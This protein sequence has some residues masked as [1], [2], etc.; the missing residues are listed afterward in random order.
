MS[1]KI[2]ISIIAAA[3][4]F[5]VLAQGPVPDFKP[6]TTFSGST[7]AGWKPMGSAEWKA[8]NGE[9][10]GTGK[11]SGG[12]LV[13]DKSYQDAGFFA[14]F[15]CSGEC[16]QG[17]LLRAQKTAD[18]MK[19]I[20]VSLAAGDLAT[21]S[22]T[23]DKEGREVSRTP[24]PPVAPFIRVAPT[25]T[26]A[27][28]AGG[29]GAGDRAVTAGRSAAGRGGR[30]MTLPVTLAPLM[31]PA[32]GLKKD[33]WNEIELII[34][35]NI[36]RPVLNTGVEIDA[37][38]TGESSGYGPVALY[39]GGASE[40]HFKD[41]SFKDL[42]SRKT[43]PEQTS[44]R[45]RM[46]RLDEFY[47]AWGVAIADFNHDGVPDIVSGPYIYLGPDFTVRKEIYIG[48]SYAPGS[49]FSPNMVTYAYDFNGDGW[50][51]VLATESRP[52]VLYV[53]PKGENR[54][55]DRYP[56]I[57]GVTTEITVF[58]DVNG[59]GRPDIVYGTA[60]GLAYATYDPANPTAPWT[61]HPVSEGNVVYAHSLGVG[62][63]NGDGRPDILQ[64]AGWWEQPPAGSKQEPWTYHPEAFG[65]WGRSE[66]AGGGEMAV[67]DVNGDGLNDVVCSLN[68]HGFGLAW[69]EQKRAGGKIS[70]ERHIVM[71]D[72]ATKNPGDV[73][74][75]EMHAGLAADVDGDGIPD[76]ITGKRH[77]SHLES[78]IDADPWGEPV[79]YWFRTVRNPKAP[80][81]AELVPELIHNRS[82]VGSHLAAA[83][84]NKDGALDIVTSTNRG[85]FVFGERRK[86]GRNKRVSCR[87]RGSAPA[88]PSSNLRAASED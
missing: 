57:N 26:A 13:S 19:G 6:D 49:Q 69:F 46:Q 59:D 7:L 44:S 74:I 42:N 85:T 22:V 39:V 32:P 29:R 38:S 78:H 17:I 24:L 80:G 43:S 28:A 5:V 62:D 8:S 1:L 64:T 4:A 20:Y 58:K 12:W 56:V 2:W 68:A 75:S 36:L 87:Y 25:A 61:S 35:A 15:R 33:G 11:G 16:R 30:S 67:Y 83:D 70:F 84:L 72:F 66:G 18:G 41:V 71:D 27:P 23:L 73:T 31:P 55:W 60:N 82:G 34:D 10:T 37:G 81:G 48:Q 14:R 54:R 47:Y 76:F 86:K 65:R 3:S 9:I 40:V 45:F 88:T 50:A 77:F 53:N 21:Y 79:L 63:I 52:M 51:D